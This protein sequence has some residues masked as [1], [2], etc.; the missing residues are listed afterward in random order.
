MTLACSVG[1]SRRGYCAQHVF[2]SS[3]AN[4]TITFIMKC[5]AFTKASSYRNKEEID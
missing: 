2:S 1:V 3:H 4:V 5:L